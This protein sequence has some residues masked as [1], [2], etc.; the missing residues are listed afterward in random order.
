[1]K[2]GWCCKK[3][4]PPEIERNIKANNQEYN[5]Q[6]E[7][8][9][10]YIC[11]SKYSII[12]FLPK[13][14]FEQL[15]RIANAYFLGLLI[16]QLI[17]QISSLP[18]YTTVVPLGFVL[19]VT[20]IKDAVDDFRRHRSDDQVNNRK[21][22]LLRDGKLVEE[23]WQKVVVGDIIKMENNQFVAADLFLLSTSEPNSLCYIETAEL[24]GETNLKVRQAIPETAEMSD[25][26]EKL[27]QFDAEI[28]CEAP[29]NR[30]P[31][32]E[33]K[34]TW[35]GE[36]HS[37]DNDKILLR[38]C[39]LRNT[40]WCY[41]LVIFSGHE[42]KLMMNCGKSVFKRTNI[43]RLMN[44]LI[45]GIFMYLL[46][47][48]L[49]CTVA[50]GIFESAINH[51]FQDYLPWESFVPGTSQGTKEGSVEEGATVISLLVFFSYIIILNTVVPISL[52]V[53]VE[54]IRMGNSLL[55][56]WDGKMYYAPKDDP[57]KARS[58]ALNEELGQ[59]EYV[60]SDKTGTLTQNIMEF[61]KASINGKAFGDYLDKEGNPMDITDATPTVDLSWNPIAEEN[62]EF[63]DERVVQEIRGGNKHMHEFFKLLSLCHTVMPDNTDGKLVYQAQSPD[64]GALVSAARNFGFAFKSRTSNSITIEVQGTEETYDLLAILDFDNVRKRMSVIVRREGKVKL[65][66][67][68]ADSVIYERLDPA[69]HN[70]QELTTHHLNEFATV[71]LRTLCLAVKDIPDSE[72]AAWS[73]KY[74]EASLAMENRDDKVDAVYEEIEQNMRLLGATAIEDKLQDGV[75]EAIA[76]LANAGI[77]IWVLTGDKQ[78]TAINIGY[79]CH[80][81]T[82]EMEEVFIIDEDD[83]DK[84]RDQIDKAISDINGYK[85]GKRGNDQVDQV[86]FENGLT[87][88]GA[89]YM[90]SDESTSV[91]GESE[92]A[93]VISGHSL[94]HCLKPE[95]EMGLL[96][97]GCLCKAVICCRVTPLQ[98]ALVVDL[99]KRNKQSI[100]LAIGD[101]AND[102]SMI[103]T[104]H[105]GVGIS[106]QEGMQAVLSS[107]FSFSQFRYLERLLLVHGRWSYL[108]MCKFLKYFFY[109]N[110]AFT[111]CH[112][113]YAFFCGFSAQ[114][115]F[116]PYFISFYNVMYTSFPVLIMGI[117]DQDVD[118]YYSTKYPKLYY[119]GLVNSLFNKKVFALSV[120]EGVVTSIVLFFIP[121]GAFYESIGP[122]GVDNADIQFFGV[123]VASILVVAV[124]LRCALDTCYWTGFS[125][126][127]IWG[128]IVYYFCFI[129]AFYASVFNY[130]YQ[131]AAFAVF[132][133]GKFWLTL[134]LTNVI[135][136][137]PVVAYR[138]YVT[139]INASLS[140]RVRMKQRLTKSKA[141]TKD[142][143]VRRT[144]T[145]R[146]SARSFRSGYAFA[147]QH[148]FAEL[149]TSGLNMRDRVAS[150]LRLNSPV[151]L[152]NVRKRID[153]SS[154]N[155]DKK[156]T[157]GATVHVKPQHPNSV[158]NVESG[159]KFVYS[160]RL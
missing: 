148:G 111:L 8:A 86:T 65:W 61:K 69:C 139:N 36:S 56:N 64:E 22:L 52:Y 21:T 9:N 44:T 97:L 79:S 93:L 145:F 89:Q 98:K 117:F 19:A 35:C 1:M 81:L 29:N 131:G 33:G 112:F 37:L 143:H 49:I 133:S 150:T 103:K 91:V 142:L 58:T 95:L 73:K 121:Y 51:N 159:E 137:V 124:N 68:G 30:L 128:S 55:I 140:D 80:L 115:L 141:R 20:G 136:L 26:N 59:I 76:N 149:I 78:E 154:A 108:R 7:Y 156:S 87:P 74:K 2:G 62:F 57:A 6:F 134:I 77:K 11:T 12:T 38:G 107:D 147:H 122:S 13:N 130:S 85:S 94:A 84:V 18:F 109:K 43:D 54:I 99:V 132:S 88:S 104:A 23:Q 41:G 92:F 25:D 34:M 50:S 114:T 53:S 40:Q 160:E 14:L 28:V 39:V 138:F 17:P 144:S 66:C 100:T 46:S 106:G 60:F 5:A 146:R 83:F 71:G 105:I 45:I 125:H 96:E 82:D 102:V 151:T 70:L 10:N 110:F 3:S 16:L 72:Y 113:W 126:F 157:N 152:T 47:M 119:P 75:P 31:K 24:D 101:G 4:R 127:F 118:D 158:D 135:L 48:C 153:S 120:T 129:M 116:D 32:F 123:V 42:T 67:K 155:V 63:Y 15:Q 27:H 90:K